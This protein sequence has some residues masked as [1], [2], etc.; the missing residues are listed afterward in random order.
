MPKILIYLLFLLLNACVDNQQISEI[1]G[2]TMGTTYTIK[3][4]DAFIDKDNIEQRLAQINQTFSTWVQDSELS[5]LNA[6]PTNEWIKVSKDLFDVLEESVKI[7][8]QTQGYFDPGMGRLIDKWGFGAIK[9]EKKPDRKSIAQALKSS[10]I[11]YLQLKELSVKKNKDVHINLS[12][13]AKGYAVDEIAKLLRAQG[14]KRFMV[15]IG[16][17]V[18]TRGVWKIGIE[19]PE[20]QVPIAIDLSSTS[21]ATSGNYRNF[22]TW[23]SKR[24]P[25]ILDSHTGTPVE[26]DLFSVS[27]INASNMRADALATAMMAMGSEKTLV[28]AKRLELKVIMVMNKAHNYKVLRIGL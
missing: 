23:E 12:A 2:N 1:S 28:L 6:K 14:V 7:N 11:K 22:F 27:V 16:G 18:A 5:L 15:E 4:Q 26:S 3:A 20:N 24:Y 25:H 19:M 8:R 13:I 9:V 17:E 21:I 10:S